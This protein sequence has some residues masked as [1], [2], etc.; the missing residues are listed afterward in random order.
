LDTEKIST[1]NKLFKQ[2]NPKDNMNKKAKIKMVLGILL[3]ISLA[4][5]ITSTVFTIAAYSG[6]LKENLITGSTIG[7]YQFVSYSVI[8]MAISFFISLLLLI[9]I[10]RKSK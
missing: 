8:F 10:I 6:N 7:Q 2:E 9:L 4:T 3:G 5:L 1:S